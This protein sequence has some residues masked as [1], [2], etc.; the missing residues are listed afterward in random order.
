[1]YRVTGKLQ[2][3]SNN[4]QII[5]P[6]SIFNKNNLKSFENIEPLY[7]LSR[8]KINKKKFRELVLFSLTILDNYEFPKEWIIDKFKDKNWLSFKESLKTI[9]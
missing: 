3:F 7:N 1:M 5:H 6:I 9:T 8:K 2:F 4:Y